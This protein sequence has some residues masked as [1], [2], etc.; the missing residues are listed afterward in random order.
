MSTLTVELKNQENVN[1]Q[2][3]QT[4]EELNLKVHGLEDSLYESKQVQLDLL[5]QLQAQEVELEK[6]QAK[7]L[8]LIELNGML[9]KH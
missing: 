7:I 5:D 6:A 8:E 4:I 9:E 1:E 3:R 2:Q